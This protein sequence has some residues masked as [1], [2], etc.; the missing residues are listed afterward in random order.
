VAESERSGRPQQDLEGGRKTI[1]KTPTLSDTNAKGTEVINSFRGINYKPYDF[2]GG[3]Y[4]TFPRSHDVWSDGSVVIV[5]A[6]G[7]T[8]DSV[9]VFVNLVVSHGSAYF[10]VGV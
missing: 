5:P 4:L 2:E 9:V 10:A 3:P 6:P 8:T 1:S 7:H